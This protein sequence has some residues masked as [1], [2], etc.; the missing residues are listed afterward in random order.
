MRRG[1]LKTAGAGVVGSHIRIP[2]YMVPL[3]TGQKGVSSFL[4]VPYAPTCS[5]VPPPPPNLVIHVSM[6][7]G[8]ASRGPFDAIWV[9]GVLH[10]KAAVYT[11]FI[12]DGTRSIEAMFT[13]EGNS[14]LD[15]SAKDSNV[16]TQGAISLLDSAHSWFGNIQRR[17]SILF[18]RAMTAIRDRNSSTAIWIGVLLSFIYGILHTL[19]PG[20]G[21]A[22]VISYFVGHGGS[23]GR[24]IRMGSQIAVFHVLSA[25]VVVLLTNFIIRQATGHVPSDFRLVKLISYS[26]I[27]VIG[28][29][30]LWQALRIVMFKPAGHGHEHGLDSVG[31]DAGHHSSCA[32]SSHSTQHAGPVGW[33]ALAVGAVPCTGALLVLLL[34]LSNDLLGPAILMV[35]AM[36]L[37]MAISMSGIGILAILGRRYVD[38]KFIQSDS[39]PVGF[40]HAIR[41][42]AA[43]LI[44]IVGI[45]FFSLTMA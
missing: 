5:H 18:T 2:G 33:L 3:K 16:L 44:V 14:V 32:C 4:L 43:A 36:S 11:P 24:G 37:G 19:G 9:E 29:Y 10:R 34:G 30:M 28:V 21:K 15:Y 35:V 20:H 38:R 12:V 17:L 13:L 7:D 1:N 39:L 45:S 8:V 42:T 26:V 27:T 31:G 6:A 23:L 40:G 22:V 41:I 25:V